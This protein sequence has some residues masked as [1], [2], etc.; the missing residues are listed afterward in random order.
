MENFPL[1]LIGASTGGPGRIHAIVSSLGAD[2]KGTVVIAQHM[3]APFIPSFIKQLAALTPLRVSDMNTRTE[4]H[5][6]SVYVCSVTSHFIS[7][8]GKLWVEP[9][10]Q[11]EY[12]Y[13]PQINV[14]FESAAHIDPS[15]KRIGIIL[16]GIGD[17]GA[18]GA[19]ALST[20]GAQCYFENEQSATVYG[21]PRCAKEL[22]PAGHM[23]SIEEIIEV[24]QDF[25]GKNVRMV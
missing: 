1:I 7:E 24:I 17:D 10:M 23:G 18:K 19:L 9:A 14:L 12:F 4:I 13:N 5:R 3:G 6:A 15:I 22:V 21:M 16:T 2:F 11:Q 8:D 20:A 25:G